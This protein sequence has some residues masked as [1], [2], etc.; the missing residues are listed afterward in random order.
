MNDD[1]PKACPKCGERCIGRF[2]HFMVGGALQYSEY[3]HG[4]RKTGF[5]RKPCRV[6]EC[7]RPRKR[8]ES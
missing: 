4:K 3:L 8:K 7:P 1:L 6:T 2:R 5:R